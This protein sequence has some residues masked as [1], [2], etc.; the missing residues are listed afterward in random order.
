MEV[1][2]SDESERLAVAE[3]QRWLVESQSVWDYWHEAPL[4]CHSNVT[5]VPDAAVA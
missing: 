5:F 2:G 1:V 3:Q 4:A